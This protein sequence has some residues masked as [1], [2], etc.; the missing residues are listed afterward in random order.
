MLFSAPFLETNLK[1]TRAH[2]KLLRAHAQTCNGF[3]FVFISVIEQ[4][5]YQKNIVASTMASKHF[6]LT[7][8]FSI[9]E[10]LSVQQITSTG[11]EYFLRKDATLTN[12]STI[13]QSVI[14]PLDSTP[15]FWY[16]LFNNYEIF[17]VHDSSRKYSYWDCKQ[18]WN[19]A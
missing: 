12:C 10:G 2:A 9:M 16:C 11:H 7:A 8:I 19:H 15:V 18:M 17:E 13:K 4:L 5:S 6:L 14:F 3:Q 1:V